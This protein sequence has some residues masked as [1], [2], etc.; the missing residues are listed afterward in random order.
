MRTYSYGAKAPRENADLVERQLIAAHRYANRLVEIERE[1]RVAWAAAEDEPAQKVAND[2]A[3]EAI[4]RARAWCDGLYWGTKQ[5]VEDAAQRSRRSG[6]EATF[7]RW[8]GTGTIAVQIQWQATRHTGL[9]VDELLA[10]TDRRARLVGAGRHRL[11][12]LRIGSTGETGRDPLWATFP[13]VYHRDLPPEARIKWVCVVCRRVGTHFKWS[14]QFVLDGLPEIT[15]PAPTRGTLAVDVGWR[16]LDGNSRVAV[17]VDDAGQ[18]GE[19]YLPADLPTRWAKVEDLRSIRDK[20]FNGALAALREWRGEATV[21]DWFR[22]A[23]THLHAW[24]ATA[25]LAA[26]S[27]RWRTQRFAGDDAAFVALELWRRQDKH[28]LEWE[29]H[30]RENVMRARREAYR[31]FARFAATYRRVVVERLDLR[32]FAELPDGPEDPRATAARGRR[33]QA[34]LS[35]LLNSMAD[36]CLRSGSEWIEAPPEWTTQTCYQCGERELFDA[37]GSVEHTCSHC[38]AAWDQDENAARNLLARAAKHEP[39][40]GTRSRRQRRVAPEET[41][42][43]LRRAKGLATRRARRSKSEVQGPEIT[44]EIW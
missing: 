28:L 1:R 14:A 41:K 40:T 10:G 5:I 23:T 44:G 15:L 26:L 30:Q 36:A 7:A 27:V 32:D 20:N 3:A 33:F 8:D 18:K 2:D 13:I 31:L 25:R 42:A 37:A 9:T 17:W 12:S 34:G 4:R 35:E 24:R 11:L 29:S 38:D 43:A 21:P 22:Q 19:L 39:G 16:R 6:R